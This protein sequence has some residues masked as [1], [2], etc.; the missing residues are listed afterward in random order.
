L[1]EETLLE[2]GPGERLVTFELS[3][4]NDGW[5]DIKIEESDFEL[6]DEDGEKHEPQLVTVDGRAATQEVEEDETARVMV[7]FELPEEA[8]PAELKYSPSFGF[9]NSVKYVFR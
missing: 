3:V 1:E 6:K 8:E 7:V 2:P 5:P 9:R 4:M